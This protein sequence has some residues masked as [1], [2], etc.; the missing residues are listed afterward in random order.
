MGKPPADE[1]AWPVSFEAVRLHQHLRFR[2]LSA[3]E[4]ILAMQNGAELV[5]TLHA[6]RAA[7]T[8]PKGK[9]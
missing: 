6:R 1:K 2:A 8:R 9:P 4:K 3:R 7:S 5:K